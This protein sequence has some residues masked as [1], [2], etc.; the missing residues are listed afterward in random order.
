MENLTSAQGLTIPI[1]SPQDKIGTR[2]SPDGQP[3]IVVSCRIS[4][5]CFGA[6]TTIV[7]QFFLAMGTTK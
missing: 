3:L 7:Y 4:N 1:R 2:P 5:Y 6:Q